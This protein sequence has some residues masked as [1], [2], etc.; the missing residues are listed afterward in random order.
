MERA[1][2]RDPPALH[3]VPGAYT[4]KK[5]DRATTTTIGIDPPSSLYPAKCTDS[6]KKKKKGKEKRRDVR[7]STDVPVI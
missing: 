7:W 6:T 3:I 4:K 1:R 5:S 2:Q